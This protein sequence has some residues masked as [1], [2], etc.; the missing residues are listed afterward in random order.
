MA[1]GWSLDPALSKGAQLSQMKA[2]CLGK[3]S[4]PHSCQNDSYALSPLNEE[5]A[6]VKSIFKALIT[7]NHIIFLPW[8]LLPN[9]KQ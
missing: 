9:K 6:N 1:A 2:P 3:K 4:L 7:S 8:L 5:K